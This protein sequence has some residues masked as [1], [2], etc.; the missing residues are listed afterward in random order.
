MCGWRRI[1]L[2][3]DRAQRV[4]HGEPPVVGCDLREEDAFE[5]AGRRSRRAAR[6]VA[7]VDRVEHLVR[8]LEHEAAQRLERLLAIPGT[9]VRAAQPRHDVD[10]RLELA[11]RTGAGRVGHG[12]PR[13]LRVGASRRDRASVSPCATML[14]FAW[15]TNTGSP[16]ITFT[17]FI[18]SLATTAAV[19][20]GD[21]A[22]PDTGERAEPN[23]PAPRR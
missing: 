8:L 9:A 2:R 6:R 17:G 18:L 4:G 12:A 16:G 19:H 15:W 22:D 3:R 13:V 21:I 11:P 14:A 1:E 7:A 5:D 10:E 23:L 20:F